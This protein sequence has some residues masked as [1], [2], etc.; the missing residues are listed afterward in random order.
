MSAATTH[1]SQRVRVQ[2]HVRVWGRVQVP[3]KRSVC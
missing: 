3:V 1:R 2:M